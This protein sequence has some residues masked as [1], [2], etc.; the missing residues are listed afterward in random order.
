MPKKSMLGVC[1]VWKHPCIYGIYDS[2][3]AV[4]NMKHEPVFEHFPM[5]IL[6]KNTHLYYIA[7]IM[8]AIAYLGL[9]V[10]TDKRAH[11]SGWCASV[12]IR[13]RHPSHRSNFPMLFLFRGSQYLCAYVDE[14]AFLNSKYL[15]WY[16]STKLCKVKS[17]GKCVCIALSARAARHKMAQTYPNDVLFVAMGAPFNKLHNPVFKCVRNQKADFWE[18][19]A[20]HCCPN[21]QFRPESALSPHNFANTHLFGHIKGMWG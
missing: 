14:A 16:K 8:D 9:W 5:S 15:V 13:G 7:C 2:D 12:Y 3:K 19:C 11:N 1:M 18:M 20:Y 17:T 4:F 10:W 6:P 21:Q